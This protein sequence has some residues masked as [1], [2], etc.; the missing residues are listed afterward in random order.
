MGSVWDRCFEYFGALVAF[1]V[2]VLRGVVDFSCRG[3]Q[4]EA[5]RGVSEA[6]GGRF[7]GKKHSKTI[8]NQCF[9][10]VFGKR[11]FRSLESFRSLL[12]LGY[13][14]FYYSCGPL[15]ALLGLFLA[16]FGPSGGPC[17]TLL[18]PA[19]SLLDAVLS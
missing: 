2:C 10:Y 14:Q 7:G 19:S 13:G 11:R 5:F 3:G 18:G 15:G 6:S 17:W 12:E 16:C 8:E 4:I 9:L 1:G